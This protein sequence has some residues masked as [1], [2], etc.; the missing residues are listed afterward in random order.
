MTCK[1]PTFNGEIDP[2]LTSTWIT[3]IEG[4]FDTRK[5]VDKEKVIYVVEMVKGEAK[6]W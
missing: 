1:P 3:K 2:I 5:C 6:H 4:T